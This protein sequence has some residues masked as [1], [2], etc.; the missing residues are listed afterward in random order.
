[1]SSYNAINGVR[2]A[3][4]KELLTDVLRGEWG[5]KGLVTTDWWGRSEHYKEVLAG[6]DIK[7][8][9]GFPDRLK[10]AMDKG[11]LTRKDLETCARR[12]LELILKVD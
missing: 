11:A 4:N 3:E 2:T 7:M 9:N 8:A 6:N 12:I 5:F 10:L 1:M